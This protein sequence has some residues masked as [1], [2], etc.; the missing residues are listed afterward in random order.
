MFNALNAIQKAMLDQLV[1]NTDAA[2]QAINI[3]AMLGD[4]EPIKYVV[5]NHKNKFDADLQSQLDQLLQEINRVE[6]AEAMAEREV[7]VIN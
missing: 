3:M 6:L 2:I 5:K 1:T 7:A 4:Y